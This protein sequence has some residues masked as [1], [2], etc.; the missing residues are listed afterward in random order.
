M[1]PF[2]QLNTFNKFFV[3]AKDCYKV[4]QQWYLANKPKHCYYPMQ[5]TTTLHIPTAIAYEQS[6]GDEFSEQGKQALR[7]LD[8]LYLFGA[9]RNTLGVYVL[10]G[11]IAQD[12]KGL[13]DDTPTSIFYNLPEWC[14]YI[15]ANNLQIGVTDDDQTQITRVLGYL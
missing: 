12:C 10:D 14:V 11:E 2:D 4:M 7:T 3:S 15:S 5:H 13:P 1:T 9:W 8:C 6:R